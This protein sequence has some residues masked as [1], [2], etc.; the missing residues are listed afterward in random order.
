MSDIALLCFV[1]GLILFYAYNSFEPFLTRKKKQ[2][3]FLMKCTHLQKC[4]RWIGVT[5]NVIR[6]FHRGVKYKERKNKKKEK[7]RKEARPSAVWRGSETKQL[8]KAQAGVVPQPHPESVW[9]QRLGWSLGGGRRRG[10]R[11]DQ[12]SH[13]LRWHSPAERG[14]GAGNAWSCVPQ[15]NRPS[16]NKKPNQNGRGFAGGF[17]WDARPIAWHV[18][19]FEQRSWHRTIASPCAD[20]R[21][22]GSV[23]GSPMRGRGVRCRCPSVLSPGPASGLS[24]TLSQ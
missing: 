17:Q 8:T 9:P 16:P 18:T 21:W 3:H 12:K 1:V 13:R 5:L 19:R 20:N 7:K 6:I 10:G 22:D 14:G 2:S 15:I 11:G 23:T 24:S 4:G